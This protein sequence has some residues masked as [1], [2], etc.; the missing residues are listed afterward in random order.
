MQIWKMMN[1]INLTVRLLKRLEENNKD[2]KSLSHRY[3][4]VFPASPENIKTRLF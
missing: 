2:E 4:L 1:H 3:K